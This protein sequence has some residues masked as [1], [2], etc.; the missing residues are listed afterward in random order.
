MLCIIHNVMLRYS[1]IWFA[2]LDHIVLYRV[3]SN[4]MTPKDHIAAGPTRKVVVLK[5]ASI[6]PYPKLEILK[7]TSIESQKC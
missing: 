3:L 7:L 4:I 5:G 1:T 2:T 6:A